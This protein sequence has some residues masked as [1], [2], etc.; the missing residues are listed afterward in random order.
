M[1]IPP[2]QLKATTPPIPVLSTRGRTPS[3]LTTYKLSRP[4]TRT[5][6][7]RTKPSICTSTKPKMLSVQTCTGLTSVAHRSDRCSPANNTSCC[8]S[9]SPSRNCPH[10]HL[11]PGHLHTRLKYT[12][13]RVVLVLVPSQASPIEILGEIRREI[14]KPNELGFQELAA[15]L[16]PLGLYGGNR[17]SKMPLLAN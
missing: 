3:K 12:I 15:I 14:G 7:S 13:G 6:T 9:L 16:S 5:T 2:L 1:S 10:T 8:L 11:G 17:K 4:T